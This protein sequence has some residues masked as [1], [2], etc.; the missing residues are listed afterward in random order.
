M[1]NNLLK[2]IKK[3]FLLL[4]LLGLQVSSDAKMLDINIKPPFQKDIFMGIR[5]LDSKVLHYKD[6]KKIPFSELS[7]ITYEAKKSLLYM[8]SDKGLLF[9][10]SAKF[11]DK[12]QSLIP[13]DA[14]KLKRKKGKRLKHWKRDSEGLTLDGKGHLLISFEGKAKVAWFHKNGK[15]YGRLI[16]RYQMPKALHDIKDYRSKNKSLEAL[17]WHQKY[18]TLTALELP[19]KKDPKKHHT[20]YSLNG[21]QWMF[22]AEP[23]PNSAI[24]AM[25][26]MED[27]NLL[28]LERSYS[29]LTSP[30]IITLKKVYLDTKKKKFCRSKVIAKF[31]TFQGW[32]IDNFEGLAKVSKN[33]YLIISDDNGNFFQKTLLVYFEVL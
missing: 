15:K 5:I 20:I 33:R 7:D 32:N 27:Q 18:G 22:K 2:K 9:T 26:V 19:L 12:I 3:N 24:V 17:T 28:V 31:N 16:R 11:T 4:L 25:E 8:I 23:H 10:F 13:L 21:K 14:T 1:K 30:F 29:G 6:I